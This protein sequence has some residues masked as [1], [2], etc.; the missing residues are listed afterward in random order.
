MNCDFSNTNLLTSKAIL[1][2]TVL[3][4]LKN[5]DNVKSTLAQYLSPMGL[6]SCLH[7]LFRLRPSFYL[8]DENISTALHLFHLDFFLSPGL[9]GAIF[10]PFLAHLQA[11]GSEIT[12]IVLCFSADTVINHSLS[13]TSTCSNQ[14]WLLLSCTRIA[15]LGVRRNWKRMAEARRLFS[16]PHLA[17]HLGIYPSRACTESTSVLPRRLRIAT[18]DQ[19]CYR[20]WGFDCP[21]ISSGLK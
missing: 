2:G 11:G 21:L 7:A 4:D 9:A 5:T 12:L 6:H 20:A 10:I 18:Q 15:S 13:H 17:H 3:F 14:D 1:K 19:I 8:S 16:I